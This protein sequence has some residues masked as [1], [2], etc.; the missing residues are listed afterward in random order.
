M[1]KVERVK[2]HIG[3]L[4]TYL[5]LI[6][7]LILAFGAGVIKLFIAQQ[8]GLL[9]WLGSLIILVLIVLFSIIAKSMHTNIEQLEEL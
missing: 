8:T 2:E 7:A 1:S 4:K 9:F 6:M 3:A 5:A